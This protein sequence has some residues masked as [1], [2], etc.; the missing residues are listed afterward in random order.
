VDDNQDSADT[1]ALLLETYGNTTFLAHDGL[2][3]VEAAEQFRP[4]VTLMDIGLPRLSGYDACRRIREQPWGRAILMIAMTGWGQ[5]EDRRESRDAGFDHHVVKPVDFD[6][7]MNLLAK[8]RPT[9][10]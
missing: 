6:N 7:L 10:A 8:A 4:E 2:D 1:L 9:T 5:D 3:A